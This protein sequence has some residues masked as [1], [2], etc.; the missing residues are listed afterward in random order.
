MPNVNEEVMLLVEFP[1]KDAQ[2]VKGKVAAISDG[3]RLVKVSTI[4]SAFHLDPRKMRT[5]VR[6]GFMGKK[7]RIH[8]WYVKDGFAGSSEVHVSGS[9][10]ST[11]VLAE[12]QETAGQL[13]EVRALPDHG[14]NGRSFDPDNCPVQEVL[15]SHYMYDMIDNEAVGGYF[16][17]KQFSTYVQW[18]I[19]IACAA[20]VVTLIVSLMGVGHNGDLNEAFQALHAD[21]LDLRRQLVEHQLNA[22][23][24]RGFPFTNNS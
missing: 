1:N 3:E 16:K 5:L 17:A 23:I 7:E 9:N 15:D 8:Y 2:W 4:K 24:A 22:T 12:P 6:K 13:T 14:P 18:A 21:N 20:S 10:G 11:V 19:F